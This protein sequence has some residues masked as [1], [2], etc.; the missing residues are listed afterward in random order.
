MH[1]G[2]HLW[3]VHH[4]L[5]DGGDIVGLMGWLLLGGLGYS[6]GGIN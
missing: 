6:M 1:H 5:E 4:V 2:Q 3:K